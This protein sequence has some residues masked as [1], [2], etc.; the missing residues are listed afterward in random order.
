MGNSSAKQNTAPIL[1]KQNFRN[2]NKKPKLKRKYDNYNKTHHGISNRE[3]V[4]VK[5]DGIT[6]VSRAGKTV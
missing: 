3:A 5:P 1:G 6:H 4:S 2:R